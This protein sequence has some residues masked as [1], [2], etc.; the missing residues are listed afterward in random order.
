MSS[1]LIEVRVSP[2]SNCDYF[3]KI[4]QATQVSKLPLS[5]AP[6]K[7][8]HSSANPTLVTTV[9]R[10]WFGRGTSNLA[11]Q[12]DPG[13][14]SGSRPRLEGCAP[15]EPRTHVRGHVGRARSQRWCSARSLEMG[16]GIRE[17]EP[18]CEPL[19]AIGSHG[20]S[21]SRGNSGPFLRGA[22]T[23]KAG[24]GSPS[25]R[26]ACPPCL[27]GFKSSLRRGFDPRRQARTHDPAATTRGHAGAV[28]TG[29]PGNSRVSPRLP[30]GSCRQCK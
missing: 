7:W 3:S 27:R 2:A 14:G 16:I 5:T 22:G 4:F 13:I 26:G 10:P 24:T 6:R 21:P 1:A 20:G 18:P 19:P 15:S 9:V 11:R 28:G 23:K 8:G 30:P 12:C 17:G 25:P 29:T